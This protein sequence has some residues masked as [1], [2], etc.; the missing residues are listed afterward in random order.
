[1]NGTRL[2][3]IYKTLSRP[4]SFLKLTDCFQER[5]SLDVADRTAKLRYNHID[6][7]VLTRGYYPFFDL[8]GY[9][10]NNLD[11]T[12]EEVAA[13]FL[14]KDSPVNLASCYV[15]VFGQVFVDKPFIVAQVEVRL[16]A[17]VGDKHLAVLER[18]HRAGIDV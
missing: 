2:T 1:M 5:Q 14:V 15:M 18:I 8:V 10:R 13:T 4:T 12:A 6:R 16:S 17:V 7:L 9:M 3:C 11:R